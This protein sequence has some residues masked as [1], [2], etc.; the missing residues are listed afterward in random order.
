MVLEI[1]VFQPASFHS[2]GNSFLF[3]FS[4][5][6]LTCLLIFLLVFPIFF[7]N[8][9]VSYI[10][11]ISWFF[12]PYSVRESSLQIASPALWLPS[13]VVDVYLS[14]VS[15]NYIL[16]KISLA[17]VQE[18][19]SAVMISKSLIFINIKIFK[20]WGWLMSNW[21]ENNVGCK[22]IIKGISTK[23]TSANILKRMFLFV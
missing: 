21:G 16:G 15:L 18:L 22:W 13:T 7:D 12:V 19:F 20:I 1:F 17:T 11:C 23:R 14:F 2:L 8:S 3:F 4:R 5:P 9:I 6:W 10:C